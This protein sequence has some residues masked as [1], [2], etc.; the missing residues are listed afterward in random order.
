MNFI[1][2][3]F[4]KYKD[5]ILYLIFGVLTT[6]VSIV[7]YYIFYDIYNLSNVTSNIISWFLS[8][9]FAFFTNKLFVFESKKW[10]KN[11]IK[12]AFNFGLCRLGSGLLELAI[13]YVCVDLLLFNGTIMKAITSFLIIVINYIASKLIIFKKKDK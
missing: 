13:M 1:K 2:K 11:A 5:I 4:F 12:E 7:S 6:I 9:G 8:V 10:N 3:L